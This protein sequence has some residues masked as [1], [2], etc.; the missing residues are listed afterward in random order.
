MT[1]EN[2]AASAPVHQ[3]V[4]PVVISAEDFMAVMDAYSAAYA[5]TETMPDDL[6]HESSV[7]RCMRRRFEE[8]VGKRVTRLLKERDWQ[9]LYSMYTK[10]LEARIL[11]L[12]QK[13]R[14]HDYWTAQ[15]RPNPQDHRAAEGGSGASPCWAD[16]GQEE[17]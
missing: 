14:E 13:I 10:Q 1:T 2:N 5:W 4:G 6:D 11:L 17:K 16:S 15:Y 8:A 12:E 3:L 7:R 9:F